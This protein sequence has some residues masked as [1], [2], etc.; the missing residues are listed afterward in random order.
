MDPSFR[1]RKNDK[2]EHPGD[3]PGCSFLFKTD[4][5]IPR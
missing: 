5:S 4:C 2:K 3:E 1:F